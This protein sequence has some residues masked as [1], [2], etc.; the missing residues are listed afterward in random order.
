MQ[1]KH[2]LSYCIEMQKSTPH[3]ETKMYRSNHLFDAIIDSVLVSTLTGVALS[4]NETAPHLP[5]MKEPG[6]R[7]SRKLV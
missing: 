5:W 2:Q 7:N 1:I 3:L 4:D 6:E